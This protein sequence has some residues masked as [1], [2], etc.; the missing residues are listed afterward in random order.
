MVSAAQPRGQRELRGRKPG[1]DPAVGGYNLL[2]LCNECAR[3]THRMLQDDAI[4]AAR[5]HALRLALAKAGESELYRLV[6]AALAGWTSEQLQ[7]GRALN[8]PGFFKFKFADAD[9]ARAPSSPRSSAAA[10]EA[11]AAAAAPVPGLPRRPQLLLAE[12][13]L[14]STRVLF[15]QPSGP[16]DRSPQIDLQVRAAARCCWPAAGLLLEL[17]LACT[18]VCPCCA[19]CPC[20]LPPCSGRRCR[21]RREWTRS[22]CRR[23]CGR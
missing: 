3:D 12:D 18:C 21:W 22:W 5:K 13:F 10:A 15:A 9:A 4:P 19:D 23:C 7:K 1:V 8:V 14:E 16:W 2:S 11:A 20:C 17:L 6:W